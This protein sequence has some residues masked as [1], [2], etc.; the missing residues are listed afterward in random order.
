MG[1]LSKAF[2]DEFDHQTV[3]A[4]TAEVMKALG[5]TYPQLQSLINAGKL[6][7]AQGDLA[8]AQ[9]VT[10][11]YNDLALSELQR[12]APRISAVQ[13][14]MDAGQAA[15]DVANLER[16]G[17][18]AGTAMRT[19]DMAASPEFYKTLEALGAKYGQ[20]LSEASPGLSAGQRAEMERGLG[21][22]QPQTADN[23]A[24]NTAEK[25]AEFGTAGQN[26]LA[27]FAD[28]VN[29]VATQLPK[30]KSG[31]NPVGLALGRD[32]R[33]GA[34][35]SAVKPIVNPTGEATETGRGLFSQLAGTQADINRMKAGA[36]KTWGDA[37]L[38]DSESFKNIASG[39]SSIAAASDRNIK[40]DFQQINN[41]AV[42]ERVL[43]LPVV[44][45]RYNDS[46]DDTHI[47]PMA[48]DFYE[49][50]KT[51]SDDKTIN[52]LDA[53]GVLIAALQGLNKKLEDKIA[54]LEAKLDNL[55]ATP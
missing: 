23:S 33:T 28:I 40:H 32:S 24:I 1:V 18:P 9:A 37:V 29:S 13:G 12:T 36:F 8:T 31:L 22:L 35:A 6:T 47:G 42:L 53:N 44:Q 10:P 45:W 7:A 26:Q 30:L 21:R 3:D 46:P 19:T 2:G 41:D 43:A 49:L 11:G 38:Q 51:G 4:Q 27:R 34:V 50:F 17:V 25:A 55:I 39:A 20:L 16:F 54:A 48:Q 52:L 5:V 15:A 14:A